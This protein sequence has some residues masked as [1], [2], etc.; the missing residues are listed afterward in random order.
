MVGSGSGPRAQRR[1]DI[2][3]MA[4]EERYSV[5]GIIGE[6]GMAT[7]YE[8]YDRLLRRSVALKVLKPSMAD[9]EETVERFFYEAELLADMDHPG[10]VAVYDRG[11]LPAHGPFYA[12][13]PVRGRTLRDI[14][15][16]NAA[17]GPATAQDQA[18]LIDIFDTVC[19]T[20]AY[21]HTRGIVHRD[22][23]PAN[24]MVDDYGVVLVL[25][26]GLSKRLDQDDTSDDLTATQTGI[27]KGTPAYM[28][29]EQASGQP[30]TV[31]YRS[32]V[33]A[34]GIILYEI[35]TGNFPFAGDTPSEVIGSVIEHQPPNPRRVNRKT[36][37]VPA[38]ICM[39]ALKKDPESRYPTA[40]EVA[41][42]IRNYRDSRPTTA[43]RP[44]P[45][46][47]IRN[48]CGRHPAWA[49]ATGMLMAIVIVLSGAWWLYSELSGY[50]REKTLEATIIILDKTVEEVTALDEDIVRFQDTLAAMPDK[51]TI[52]ALEVR[53]KIDELRTARNMYTET[54]RAIIIAIILETSDRGRPGAS[55]LDE[56]L[57]DA[58]RN[59]I[60]SEARDRIKIGD[61]YEAHNLLW[62]SVMA[63]SEFEWSHSQMTELLALK[64]Q[65]ETKIREGRGP[66]FQLPDWSA[67][68]PQQAFGQALLEADI[69][70]QEIY[71]REFLGN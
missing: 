63:A 8:G 16:G 58:L 12:M 45:V 66:D 22:L 11:V 54:A 44:G 53:G 10:M 32:D 25:D 38:A 56:D 4:P 31:D 9:D 29:P 21:A 34:L 26:W 50:I 49:T 65:V 59:I 2:P 70:S 51:S 39:K 30:K 47:R 13:K 20:V 60:L 19:Q 6:G 35:L 40:R 1:T 36:G 24:I 17:H 42:D 3:S 28:S 48:W 71:E 15:R 37:R 5:A 68:S 61:L 55:N 33:F 14:L 7:V 69:I 23:K 62:G 46:H 57:A 18:P 52:E 27:V 64:D 41:D 43:Y 67:Y